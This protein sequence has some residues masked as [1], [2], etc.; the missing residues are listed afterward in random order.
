M[1][2]RF[3]IF[4]LSLVTACH[5]HGTDV[6]GDSKDHTPFHAI[7]ADDVVKFTGTEP[8]WS[9]EVREGRLIYVTPDDPK[10]TAASVSRFAGRGG[11]SYSGMLKGQPFT[12][13]VTPA[14]CSDG[15][16]DRQYPFAVT[17]LLGDQLRK[18]CAWTVRNSRSAA[19]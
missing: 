3:A 4:A 13:A 17:M 16:S 14:P 15:M 7:G 10:G 5:G 2:R 19:E 6:P 11:L 9:G 18:G 8:F 12:L 1:L